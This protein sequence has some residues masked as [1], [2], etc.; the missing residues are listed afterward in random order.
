MCRAERTLTETHAH[1][2]APHGVL[3]TV[4]TEAIRAPG[5]AET[6]RGTCAG[7][8][9]ACTVD[10][11]KARGTCAGTGSACTVGNSKARGTCAGIGFARTAGRRKSARQS[12][13]SAS[14]P[15][16]LG[17][18]ASPVSSS[19]AAAGAAGPAPPPGGPAAGARPRRLQDI[20]IAVR[21]REAG[22]GNI[23]SMQQ[24]GE[25]QCPHLRCFSIAAPPAYVARDCSG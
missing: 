2:P 6:A 10:N 13:V 15:C 12:P 24:R 17:S 9:S 14:S 16:P 7:T 4:Q 11:S 25:F 5:A 3:P 21:S 22:S 23:E 8:G 19:P 1:V 18:S 20:A